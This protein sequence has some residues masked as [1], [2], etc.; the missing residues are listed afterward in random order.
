MTF[1]DAQEIAAIN[2]ARPLQPNERAAFM[3]AL[4]A[5]FAGR[6]EIGDG[7]LG[8]TLRDLQRK[9]FRPPG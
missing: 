9:Q 1:T 8:R 6:N 3:T 7:E 4:E 2:A 5:V